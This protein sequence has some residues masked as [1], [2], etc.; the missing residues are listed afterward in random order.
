MLELNNDLSIHRRHLCY[1]TNEAFK[2]IMHLEPQFV[3]SYLEEKP[4]L[5]NLGDG[6]K[7]VLPKAKSSCFGINSLLF[8]GC[9][10]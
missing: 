2:S 4:M 5:Y 3:W 9:L 8:R 10:L 1:L 6:T 7:L